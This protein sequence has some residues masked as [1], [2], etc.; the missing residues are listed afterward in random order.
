MPV[1]ASNIEEER[2]KMEEELAYQ[3]GFLRSVEKS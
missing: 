1:A 2:N 3:E